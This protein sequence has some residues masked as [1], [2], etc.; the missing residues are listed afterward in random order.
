[1]DRTL[2]YFS[3]YLVVLTCICF[4]YT[5]HTGAEENPRS[6]GVTA[7]PDWLNHR[8]WITID[9]KPS[10]STWEFADDEIRLINPRG[11]SGSLLSPPLPP[12]FELQ[13]S[14]KID[15]G[16][17]SGLKYRVQEH[18]GKWLGL[19]YQIIDEK[20]DTSDKSSTGSVYD[21]IA[22]IPDKP[23][24]S[25]GQWNQS[26][27]VA[28]G[29]QIQH[30]LNGKLISEIITSGTE[31]NSK[32]AK[33]KFWGLD[34]F[35]TP[36]H[37]QRIMLTDHGGKASF[38][39]FRWTVMHTDEAAEKESTGP[40]LGNGIKNGW[41]DQTSA[42]IWTRT[43]RNKGMNF[44]GHTFVDLGT[45]ELVSL[46][47]KN[48]ADDF[49]RAQL[50][51]GASLEEMQGAC[52]G[53]EAEVRLSYFP[54][55]QNK[56]ILS[57]QWVKT[58]PNM[59]FTAQ[60]KIKDLIPNKTYA[61]VIEV[62]PIGETKLS[63]VMR[64]R[65]C[66]APK[67]SDRVPTR[68]CL[69]TCHD[70]LR[71]DDGFNGHKIYPSMVKQAPDFTIHAGDIE[72]YD[73]PLPW[74][75]T[76]ELMRF[77]WNRIFAL[78][79]NRSFYSNHTAYFLKDDHDTLKNDCWPGQSYGAVSF[80]EGQKIFNDE[81][82]PSSD[83]RYQTIHWGKDLQIWLLEGRDFRSPNNMDDGPQKTIL[84]ANQKEWLFR[85][86]SE[87]EA[88]FKLVIS[89][90]PIIG[91]DRKNK[92]DNHANAAYSHEGEELRLRLSSHPGTIVFCGDRHWQYA[93]KDN[94][95]NLW[96]F[97]C[98]PGSEKH[99]LGWKEG[100]LDENHKFLRVAGGFMSGELVY[101][102]SDPSKPNLVLRHHKV[103]GE[104][105]SEF[106]F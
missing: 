104:V 31:W 12:N 25:A 51:A 67:A 66:T 37:L 5:D 83:I 34:D 52:P 70:F 102:P 79:N 7:D 90:T 81:Q 71:R 3:K 33:S 55:K 105:V 97:G 64:G 17:N 92:R 39:D 69:T 44:D 106:H 75:L 36:R 9:G 84:G 15:P 27:I 54:E 24:N 76:K 103:T 96:E 41:I 16:T 73:K 2:N 101:L 57:T 85:T 30:Y 23:L 100:D 6:I 68:F 89:P 63:A 8:F 20:P 14:W 11:G 47:R 58:S 93:T 80:E 26:K 59:D 21:L 86:L 28:N 77:K 87:S 99:Q 43:T 45:A 74:A 18:D 46:Q 78:T 50:P 40:Y 4:V 49:L 53:A 29:N 82:F 48:S 22:P 94:L 56:S 38:K 88:T 61:T 65:F 10:E 1:M 62:R 60:W 95:T 35:G 72:Y 91:P 13:W 32:L 19:E 42:V 98:G